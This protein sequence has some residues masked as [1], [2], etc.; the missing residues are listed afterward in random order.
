MGLDQFT[1]IKT[2]KY[3][4]I[5]PLVV[6][7]IYSGTF[8]ID[9]SYIFATI[10]RFVQRWADHNATLVDTESIDDIAINYYKNLAKGKTY[11][12]NTY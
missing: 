2:R 8:V 12:H 1:Q 7:V 5:H 10:D 3:V 6:V 9:H 11:G 4:H